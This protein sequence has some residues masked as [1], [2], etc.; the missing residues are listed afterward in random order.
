MNLRL[1]QAAACTLL[2]ALALGCVASQARAE[3]AAERR[4]ALR[5]ATDAALRGPEAK[6]LKVAGH[7]FNVKKAQVV[8]SRGGVI[9]RGQISHHLTLRPDDQLYYTIHKRGGAVVSVDMKIDRGGLSSYVGK[10]V[11]H[12]TKLPI[13][14]DSAE[15][16]LRR[17]GG[18]IDGRWESAAELIVAAVALGVDDGGPVAREDRES[19]TVPTRPR[20]NGPVV[21]DHRTTRPGP[22][23]RD[24]RTPRRP[25]STVRDHRNR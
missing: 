16:V 19:E 1:S 15:A 11:G 14:G 4:A 22:V 5:R 24:H 13:A 20:P 3:S 25:M 7:E 12:F 18:M 23:V 8:R 9:V 17:L 2:A 6:K 21:R 10:L